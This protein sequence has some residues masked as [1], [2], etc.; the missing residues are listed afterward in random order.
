MTAPADSPLRSSRD[1]G[2]D[3]APPPRREPM[4]WH[5][6]LITAVAVAAVALVACFVAWVVVT[7]SDVLFLA[8]FGV[9]FGVFLRFCGRRLGQP[10]GGRTR[11]GIG[12]T[13]VVLLAAIAS[14][15]YFLG[16]R[17]GSQL[18]SALR[19][20]E[21]AVVDL[22][23]ELDERPLL[24]TVVTEV[25]LFKKTL[26]AVDRSQDGGGDPRGLR[27][28][29][30]QRFGGG[31]PNGSGA[32]G[33]ETGD[34]SS[35]GSGS[36]GSGSGGSKPGAEPGS[37]GGVAVSQFGG[38][39]G[40]A[41]EAAAG[42]FRTTLGTITSLLVIFFLGLF[43]A[44]D[45]GLY[46]GGA[47]KLLPR[48]RREQFEHL[49][50]DLGR[51]LWQWMW[52]QA[53]TMLIT[54]TGIG[55]T[56]WVL[57]VPLPLFLGVFSGLMCFV[58]NV[59]AAVSV[60]VAMLLAVPQG[61]G[62]VLAVFVSFCLFQLLESNVITPLIQKRAVSIPPALLLFNQL[63][64]GVLFGLL[65]IVVATP[66]LAVGLVAINRVYVRDEFRLLAGRKPAPRAAL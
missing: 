58:P 33:G 62:T 47:A 8:F 5:R 51:T 4:T 61:M 6:T 19:Q 59:G 38:L 37:S 54:G 11:F 66:L 41:F 23:R 48:D 17:I 24:N 50:D 46:R 26:E 55:L 12:V 2:G 42:F 10:I 36:G 60:A 34:G 65:G 14:V 1:A 44:Y 31:D 18:Q 3:A 25:P 15:T 13:V 52:A 32:D 20:F 16:D 21:E 40:R 29:A 22:R 35:G 56:M 27:S 45:P 43:M 57:G 39:G 63:L 28:E 9:A 7:A 30:D 64:F 53:L 49:C